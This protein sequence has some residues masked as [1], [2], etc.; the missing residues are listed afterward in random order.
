MFMNSSV[1]LA[2]NEYSLL[3]LLLYTMDSIIT[4]STDL[5]CDVEFIVNHDAFVLNTRVKC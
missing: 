5:Q 3:L 1:F 2:I 4:I